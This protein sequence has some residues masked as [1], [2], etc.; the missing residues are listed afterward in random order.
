MLNKKSLKNSALSIKIFH[1]ALM[2][3]KLS[4]KSEQN[5]KM[6]KIMKLIKIQKI[7]L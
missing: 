2:W 7:V 1:S 3:Y 5:N 6:S 4:Y